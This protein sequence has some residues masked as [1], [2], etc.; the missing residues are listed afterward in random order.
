[1]VR[2]YRSLKVRLTSDAWTEHGS[3]QT[4]KQDLSSKGADEARQAVTYQ[5]R[6]QYTHIADLSIGDESRINHG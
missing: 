6:R 3:L 5:A 4:Y 1:M 2:F